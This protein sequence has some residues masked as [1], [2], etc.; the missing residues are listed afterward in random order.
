M[1]EVNSFFYIQIVSLICQSVN[2]SWKIA[3]QNAAV[4]TLIFATAA[5][6][7]FGYNFVASLMLIKIKKSLSLVKAK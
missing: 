6:I 5:N 2:L 4:T 3:A 1:W 7:T